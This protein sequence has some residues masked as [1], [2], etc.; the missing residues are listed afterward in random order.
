KEFAVLHRV[1][2][3]VGEA[4]LIAQIHDVVLD[5]G[6]RV[7]AV[8]ER[9]RERGGWQAGGHSSRAGDKR[10]RHQLPPEG[11]DRCFRG[12]RAAEEVVVDALEVEG[13][14]ELLKVAVRHAALPYRSSSPIRCT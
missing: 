14:N 4:A 3:P 9:H 10:L 2:T 1:D 6:I 12:V 11:T 13:G 7:A 5:V 8:D